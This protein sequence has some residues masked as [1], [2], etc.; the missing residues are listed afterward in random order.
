M[1][2]LGVELK[3]EDAP[4]EVCNESGDSSV[5][6]L[7]MTSEYDF[8]ALLNKIHKVYDIHTHHTRAVKLFTMSICILLIWIFI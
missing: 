7:D 1:Q 2:I 5:T 8:Y 6:V 3:K 4:L